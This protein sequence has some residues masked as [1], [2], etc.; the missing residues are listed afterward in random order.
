MGTATQ[1]LNVVL[2]PAGKISVPSG[3]TL[4]TTGTT[5]NAY[6]GALRISY[7]F[8]TA[9]G[10]GGSISLRAASDFMPPGGPSIAAGALVYACGAAG[11]GAPCAGFQTVSTTLATG[12]ILVPE[13]ACTGGGA[14]CSAAD[15]AV[16]ELQFTLE[17]SPE[18]QTGS[19]AS[20]LVLTVSTL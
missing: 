15:P 3:F 14:P 18:Y 5:F 7:R 13:S 1:T 19:Y 6:R 17:N 8:R 11:L 10:G 9:P 16:V 2:L 12:V 4:T 20:S